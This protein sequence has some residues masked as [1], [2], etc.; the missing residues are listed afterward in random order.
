MDRVIFTKAFDLRM[1]D[2]QPANPSTNGPSKKQLARASKYPHALTLA[3]RLL[4]FDALEDFEGL[5]YALLG[6]AF[7]D[8]EGYPCEMEQVCSTRTIAVR[9][10]GVR[11]VRPTL[12][13]Q[14]DEPMLRILMEFHRHPRFTPQS[15]VTFMHVA[16]T[17]FVAGWAAAELYDAVMNAEEERVDTLIADGTR[18]A[19]EPRR[20]VP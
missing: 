18:F 12:P 19:W 16:P 10:H 11:R 2:S 6:W 20:F 7:E 15:S 5:A 4:N 9:T 8:D 13:C 14:P 3:E 17:E 1:L